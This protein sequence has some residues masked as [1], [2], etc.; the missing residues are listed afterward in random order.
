MN[1][2]DARDQKIRRVN[3]QTESFTASEPQGKGKLIKRMG[4]KMT[5][6]YVRPFGQAQNDFN[7]A[8]ADAL[9]ALHEQVQAQQ[10]ALDALTEQTDRRLTALVQEQRQSLARSRNAQQESLAALEQTMNEALCAADPACR[11]TAGVP[12]MTTLSGLSGEAL[13]Q[14]LQAVK[15][16]EDASSLDEAMQQLEQRYTALLEESLQE[17][18]QDPAHRPIFIVCRDY[19]ACHKAIREETDAMYRLLKTAS[20]YPVQIVSVMAEEGAVSQQGDVYTVPEA[21]LSAFLRDRK[22]SLLILC[23]GT[24][25]IADAGKGCML[26]YNSLYRLVSEAPGQALGGSRMQ[27]LLHLCDYGVHRYCTV[28]NSAADAMQVLGFR[29]PAVMSLPADARAFVCLVEDCADHPVPHGVIHAGEWDRQL[30]AENRHL[31]KGYAALKAY[32]QRQEGEKAVSPHSLPY[33]QNCFVLMEQQSITVLLSHL[34]RGKADC[35]LLDVSAAQSGIAPLLAPFGKCTAAQPDLF[36]GSIDG[37][38]DVITLFHILRHYE[39]S[40]RQRLWETVKRALA[41]NGLLLFDVPNLHFEVPRRHQNGWGKYPLYD[42]FWTKESLRRELADHGLCAEA[43]LPVGQ[44]L[45]SVSGVHRSEPV[46]WTAA[47]RL[48]P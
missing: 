36:Y 1:H 47:V 3:A 6:W 7:A 8:A 30:K 16:A 14:E 26:M 24:T 43:L 15:H 35:R 27:D 12:P 17:C 9:A 28:S 21:A 45:Y 5:L 33:P 22:P 34:L 4:R 2:D 13:F 19:A 32:Y 29:R 23:G 10:A 42:V 37:Q 38:Y 18:S 20:R 11:P 39:Y 40:D 48:A 46:S 31:I 25:A 41:P 44:G